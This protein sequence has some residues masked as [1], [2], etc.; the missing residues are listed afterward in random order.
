[1]TENEPEN[2]TR[3]FQ[4]IRD[5]AEPAAQE[6]TKW[7]TE[8]SGKTIIPIIAIIAVISMIIMRIGG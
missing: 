2:N 1:M 3:S 4:R 5:A 7:V 8:R 6:W